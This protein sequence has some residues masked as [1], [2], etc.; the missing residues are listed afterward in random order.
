MEKLIGL[1][2]PSIYIFIMKARPVLA[3]KLVTP[4]SNYWLSKL[5]IQKV[6]MY[7]L[8]TAIY[9]TTIQEILNTYNLSSICPIS[10]I[11]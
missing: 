2:L 8:T 3:L 1:I 9:K 6:L 4:N 11:F 10:T 7:S 5:A